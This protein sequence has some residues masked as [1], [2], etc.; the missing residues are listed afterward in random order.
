M[1]V[2][3][4]I[5][6]YRVSSS[7]S[8]TDLADALCVSRQ[9][10]SKWETNAAL[11]ELDKLCRMSEIFDVTLDELVYGARPSRGKRNAMAMSLR[12]LI[13]P[14]V[15]AG[16]SLLLFG[17]VFFL[18]SVF[19]GDHLRMGEAMGEFLSIT[20]S[21]LGLSMIALYNT[22]VL[23]VC[24]VIYF[25]YG[26]TCYGIFNVQ[27]VNNNL[28]FFLAGLV[29]LVWFIKWGLHNEKGDKKMVPAAR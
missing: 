2:G 16:S 5:H 1:N 20:I 26:I 7:M 14:R 8:Q 23:S 19:W 18:L 24:G 28:F 21:L 9:S 4:N 3:E 17:M 6:S 12:D 27:S 25:L 29:L 10:V 11:P 22:Q 13:P 15:L